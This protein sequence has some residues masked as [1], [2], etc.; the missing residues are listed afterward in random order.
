MNWNILACDG[1][2]YFRW[3]WN[4]AMEPSAHEDSFSSGER[5]VVWSF[6]SILATWSGK[7]WSLGPASYPVIWAPITSADSQASPWWACIFTRSLVDSMLSLVWEALS[8]RKL[9]ELLC[10]HHHHLL[11]GLC[12]GEHSDLWSG[13]YFIDLCIDWCCWGLLKFLKFFG[14]SPLERLTSFLRRE[15]WW[16]R[17][18]F[19]CFSSGH[20]AGSESAMLQGVVRI[21]VGRLEVWSLSFYKNLL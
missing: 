15:V 5:D 9:F 10:H 2:T 19:F 21:S 4:V 7:E 3:K 16:S 8:W 14:S 20:F 1:G 12:S 11:A 6:I 18:G 13:L 17:M